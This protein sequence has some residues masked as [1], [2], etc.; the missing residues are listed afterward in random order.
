MKILASYPPDFFSLCVMHNPTE[1]RNVTLAESDGRV[2]RG[3]YRDILRFDCYKSKVADDLFE[4][5][6]ELLDAEA[7]ADGVADFSKH[8]QQVAERNSLVPA[9]KATEADTKFFT[10]SVEGNAIVLT[11]N[12]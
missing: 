5:R 10:I 6:F 12:V 8:L 7:S 4:Y 1:F 11:T 2:L 3:T 9:G